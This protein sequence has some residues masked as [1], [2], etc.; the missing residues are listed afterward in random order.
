[1]CRE[2]PVA[3]NAVTNTTTVK[4]KIPQMA[5]WNALCA[6]FCFLNVM[7]TKTRSV[8]PFQWRPECPV[9][10]AGTESKKRN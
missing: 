10:D 2:E 7:D 1:V 4:I 3:K 6:R 9:S 5:Y 8:P